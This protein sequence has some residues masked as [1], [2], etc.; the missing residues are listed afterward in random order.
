MARYDIRVFSGID[1]ES[2]DA[3]GLAKF[4]NPGFRERHTGKTQVPGKGGYPSEGH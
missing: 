3:G 2:G 4:V 1:R